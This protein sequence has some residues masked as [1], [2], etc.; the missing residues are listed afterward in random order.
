M[1][2][3]V[4][5]GGSVGTK[6]LDQAKDN[7]IGESGRADNAVS[8]AF[9]DKVSESVMVQNKSASVRDPQFKAVVADVERALRG[10]KG[11]KNLQGPYDEGN[12]GKISED[13][14]SALITFDLPT[15]TARPRT[16][17]GPARDRGEPGQA[18]R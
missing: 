16:W 1:I 4:F 17:S 11:V 10:E 6:T 8:E 7:G 5:I 3:A 12:A 15:R 9:P 18:P 13:G 14:H 2:L